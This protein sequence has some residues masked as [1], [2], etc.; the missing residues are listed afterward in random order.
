MNTKQISPISR[1]TLLIAGLFLITVLYVPIWSIS[2]D[3]PQYPE[4]LSMSI[5]ANKLGGNVDIINGLNHYIGMKT[6]HNEDFPE[7]KILPYCVIFF[8]LFF[9]VTAA[10]AKRKLLYT[11]LIM[12]ILFGVAA[13]VDF[14]NWEYAYGHNLNPD[15]AIK[16]PGMSYQPPLIGYKQLLNFGAFSMPA[17]G[18]WI[19]I[20]AGILLLVISVV[21]VRK[22]KKQSLGLSSFVKNTGFIVALI[23]LTSCTIG[24]EPIKIGRDNCYYCK[25]TI[26]DN[27]FGAEIVTQKGKIYL[28]DD[29]DCM[30]KFV[31]L[32]EIEKNSIK[33]VYLADFAGTRTLINAKKAFIVRSDLISGPMN[34][35]LVG[36][37]TEAL[38]LEFINTKAGT[39]QNWQQIF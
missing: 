20:A 28:F 5:Y 37:S 13:M 23:S 4:G 16:V 3:A 19:F 15:A 9:I 2:L 10:I 25:M 7:F 26:A 33:D 35:K 30:F 24:P 32:K 29:I 12:F 6:L 34:G 14:W 22:A 21:E 27:R 31:K 18:G 8:S 11:L 38:A 39:L 17:I 36:F 1:I